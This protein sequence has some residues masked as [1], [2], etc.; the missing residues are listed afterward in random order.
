MSQKIVVDRSGGCRISIACARFMADRGNEIAIQ[1][2]KRLE[3]D[4]DWFGTGYV[5]NHRGYS[6]ID[7]DLIAAVETLGG[8]ANGLVSDLAVVEIPDGVEWQIQEYDGR[9]W[10]AEKHR[11]W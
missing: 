2:L 7:P 3:A 11:T 1:E 9:E 6:R 4:G 5:G 8:L 10:I